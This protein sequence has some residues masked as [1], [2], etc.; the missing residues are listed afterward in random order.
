MALVPPYIENLRPYEAGRSIEEVQRE[1]SLTEV[2]KLASNENPLGP[3]PLALERVS[4]AMR[5]LHLYPDGGL[6]IRRV[7]AREFDLKVDNVIAGSGSEGIM[8]NII[9]TFLTDEDE[10]LTTEAAF[11]GFQVLAKSR[12]VKYRTVPYRDWHYDLTALATAVNENTKIIYLAN[13]NNPTGTIFTRAEFD[14]FYKHVPE[15]VLIILDE[16][17]FEYAKDNPRYPDSMHY[18]YDNVITLRTFSKVYGL[19]G[20]RIGYAFAHE[21]LIRNVLKVKLPFEP[22]TLAQAAGIGALSDK[23]FLHRALEINARGV[24]LLTESLRE[25]GY[26]VVPSEANFVML[27]LGSEDQAARFTLDLLKQGIIIRPLKSFGLPNCVRISTG[28]DHDHQRCIEAIEKLSL[29]VKT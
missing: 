17:Y 29:A 8:S 13:P 9:R 27:V 1:Y 26:H 12:G 21:D 5:N 16:A 20:L 6:A 19:A 14:A 4:N 24:R 3:S 18:R 10:V 11:I 23:A 22:G 28:S 15:R 2:H 7:L 25:L